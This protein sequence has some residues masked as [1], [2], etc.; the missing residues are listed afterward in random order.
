[1]SPK[2][3]VSTLYVV[4]LLLNGLLSQD[5]ILY[6]EFGVMLEHVQIMRMY[7]RELLALD[8]QRRVHEQRFIPV[9][10]SIRSQQGFQLRVLPYRCVCDRRD[11]YDRFGPVRK[12]RPIV[13]S[14]NL[15][16]FLGR[17]FPPTARSSESVGSGLGGKRIRSGRGVGWGGPVEVLWECY[18]TNVYPEYLSG[19][20]DTFTSYS[21]LR[22]QVI[23]RCVFWYTIAPVESLDKNNYIVY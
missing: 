19:N 16:P 23:T 12:I 5:D 11:V 8:E 14:R 15:L 17:S 10:S 22:Y 20:K 9:L 18:I 3:A 6:T 7:E 4:F 2:S 1:M 13:G 21:I